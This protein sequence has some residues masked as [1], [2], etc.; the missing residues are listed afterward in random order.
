MPN[1]RI[2]TGRVG[3]DLKI[4]EGEWRL[5]PIQRGKATRVSYV[6][7]LALKAPAPSGMIR[8]AM[9]DDAPAVLRALR[10]EATAAAGG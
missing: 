8:G 10:R 3:G 2:T 5:E 1:R 9:R 6:S 4:A 7:R